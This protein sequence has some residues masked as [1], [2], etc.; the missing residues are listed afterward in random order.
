MNPRLQALIGLALIA[1][2]I[3]IG[4]TGAR[5]AVTLPDPNVDEQL[6][7]KK[8]ERTII[9]AGGCFWGIEAVFEHL[10][11]VKNAISGYSGGSANTAEYEVVSS[12]RTGHAESVK[13]TYD[14]SQITVGQLLKIFFA[15]A[16]DPTQLNRQGPD[17]GTQ[18]RSV[19]FFADEEQKRI[20]QAYVTQLDQA[21]VF[22][23]RIV[24]EVIPL[25]AFYQAEDYHQDYLRFHPDQPY[26]VYNDLP[27]L[28][29]LRKQFPELY[30]K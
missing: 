15:V 24:T 10:K 12:G 30:K 18:Y 21:K 16:H 26:I 7:T 2:T 19:I 14:P 8:G 17:I 3:T 25:K 29:Q 22:P 27:K 23:T 20:A 13:V 4:C 5:A 6:A 1:V 9:V 11:G 28:E